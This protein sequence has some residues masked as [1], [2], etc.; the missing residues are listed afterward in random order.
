MT[1]RQT[2]PRRFLLLLPVFPAVGLERA[3]CPST[4]SAR[5]ELNQD[6]GTVTKTYLCHGHVAFEQH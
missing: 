1:L 3:D 2:E 6:L 4:A 5:P